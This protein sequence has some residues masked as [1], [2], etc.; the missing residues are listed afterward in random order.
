MLLETSVNF[1]FMRHP[2][3]ITMSIPEVK[4][5][6]APLTLLRNTFIGRKG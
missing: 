6:K 2:N 4:I 1:Y 3:S 5:S